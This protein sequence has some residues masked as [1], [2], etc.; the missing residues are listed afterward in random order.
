METFRFTPELSAKRMFGG[1][2]IMSAGRMFAIAMDDTLYL[3]VDAET[4]AAFEAEGLEPFRFRDRPTRNGGPSFRQAPESVFE[5]ED[6]ARRWG[7]MAVDAAW[8][9]PASSPAS[10]RGRRG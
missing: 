5:D 7:G 3:K 1:A 6:E 10:V 2:G 8:R 9:K 4:Q